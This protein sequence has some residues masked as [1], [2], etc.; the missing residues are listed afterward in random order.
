MAK[1]NPKTKAARDGH[2]CPYHL[3]PNIGVEYAAYVMLAGTAK[4]GRFNW[5]KTPIEFSTY[6]GAIRR[7]LESWFS[8]E[9]ND[10]ESGYHP[11]AHVIANCCLVLDAIEQQK[12]IDDRHEANDLSEEVNG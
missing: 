3:L 6:Y 12:A 5:R 4:Y 7:H 8:G 10:S 1:I 9:N 11:L 2:R